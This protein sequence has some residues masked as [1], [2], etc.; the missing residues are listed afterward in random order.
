MNARCHFSKTFARKGVLSMD[1]LER[2]ELIAQKTT[3]YLL[4]KNL[5]FRLFL[6]VIFVVVF[7]AWESSFRFWGGGGLWASVIPLVLLICLFHD[8]YLG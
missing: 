3:F 5:I 4:L 7:T 8:V 6:I 1:F 2:S